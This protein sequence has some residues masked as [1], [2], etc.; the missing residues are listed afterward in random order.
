M[1]KITAI[2]LILSLFL[3][4]IPVFAEETAQ[5]QEKEIPEELTKAVTLFDY[6]EVIEKDFNIQKSLTDKITRAEFS[7]YLAK[8]LKFD[9]GERDIY[10][11]DVVNGVRGANEISFLV[12]SGI[13]SLADDN[14]FDPNDPLKAE[15]AIKMMLKANGYSVVADATGGYP[16]GYTKTAQRLKLVPEIEDME[17]LTVAEALIIMYRAMEIGAYSPAVVS[18]STLEYVVDENSLFSLYWD[19]FVAEGQLQAFYGMSITDNY[20]EEKNEVIIS[21]DKFLNNKELDLY[22]L[23]GSDIEFLYQKKDDIKELIYAEDIGKEDKLVINTEDIA[24]FDSV[25]YTLKYYANDVAK[26]KSL[27]RQ[28]M[29]VYNG[30]LFTGSPDEV[31]NRLISGEY[32]GVMQ[33]KRIND[34]EYVIV[35]AYKIYVVGNTAEENTIL[36][37]KFNPEDKRDLQKYIQLSIKDIDSMP[38][39]INK[40]TTKVIS[41]AESMD[42]LFAEIVICRSVPAGVVEEIKADS[43]KIGGTE[44]KV[45]RY[46]KQSG[47]ALVYMGGNY[48]VYTDKYGEIV[49]AG[50]AADTFMFGYIIDG[51]IEDNLSDD[52]VLKIAAEDGKISVYKTNDTVSVDGDRYSGKDVYNVLCN[53]ANTLT[54]RKIP[55]RQLIRY[56]VNTDGK[57]SKIDTEKRGASETEMSMHRKAESIKQIRYQYDYGKMGNNHIVDTKKTKLFLI[58]RVDAD[59]YL[60]Q[61]LYSRGAYWRTDKEYL[62]DE[63]GNKVKETDYM[64]VVNNFATLET[65]RFYTAEIFKVDDSSLVTDAMIVYYDPYVESSEVIMVD[66]IYDGMSA[67]GEVSKYINGYTR[68]GAVNYKVEVESELEGIN[69]GDLIRGSYNDNKDTIFT[70]TRVYN[71]ETQEFE[72]RQQQAA[73][74]PVY[75][76]IYPWFQGY[77]RY[78]NE[79]GMATLFEYS[80][81]RQLSKGRVIQKDGNYVSL[82]WD[83]DD[84][85]DETVDVTGLKINVCS[86]SDRYGL[87]VRPGTIE[88]ILDYKTAGTDCSRMLVQSI[89]LQLRALWIYND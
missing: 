79:L 83:G 34:I 42:G 13:I 23:T 17:D 70:I 81:S 76:Y 54:E 50:Y 84:I 55:I 20:V 40:G 24:A 57:I 21:E 35:T 18:D 71:R 16:A 31:F 38:A 75:T 29:L 53:T 19:V 15:H 69:Q 22:D 4:Q 48:S 36:Y 8:A 27:S 56:A 14:K 2:L 68:Y 11:T 30:R 78:D 33:I 58:P 74:T 1:K 80:D 45:D 61:D 43:V 51:Y 82:D 44:Y 65:S 52:L 87:E 63:N 67:D 9:G 89:Y 88:D 41:L 72:N 39:V 49:Y 77:I 12:E 59:G 64:F 5:V 86:R 62:T 47:L 26:E 28:M 73:S 6:I 46:A 3:L 7:V 85:A 60:Y 32:K 66:E 37:N 25:A 10:F